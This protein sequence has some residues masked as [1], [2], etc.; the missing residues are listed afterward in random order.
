ML[1]RFTYLMMFAEQIFSSDFVSGD[2]RSES[3]TDLLS[4]DAHENVNSVIYTSTPNPTLSPV[5]GNLFIDV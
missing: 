5:I 2:I 4:T 3:F 1:V